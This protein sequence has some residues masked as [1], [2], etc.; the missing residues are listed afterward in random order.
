MFDLAGKTMM[1]GFIDPHLHPVQAASML[2]PRY[3]TPFDWKFPWGDAAAVRGHDPFVATLA[4]SAAVFSA[5]PETL[6]VW[7]YL[8]PITAICTGGSSASSR[9]PGPSS[10]GPIPRMSS[11]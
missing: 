1:P 10:S 11:T 8:Q 3:A 5:S 6:I 9:Q 4:G 2:M 7:G